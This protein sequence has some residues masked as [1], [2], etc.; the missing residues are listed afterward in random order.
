[1]KLFHLDYDVINSAY[2]R[3]RVIAPN[4]ALV[5]PFTLKELGQLNNRFD[6]ESYRTLNPNERIR[7]V[8]RCNA[9]FDCYALSIERADSRDGDFEVFNHTD[10][11]RFLQVDAYI[12]LFGGKERNIQEFKEEAQKRNIDFYVGF[13]VYLAD[14]LEKKFSQV[15]KP[16]VGE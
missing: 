1:M 15:E 10:Y 8:I 7:E 3:A 5:Q 9:P 11:I 13:P 2:V 6:Y 14:K 12:V 16:I 4:H